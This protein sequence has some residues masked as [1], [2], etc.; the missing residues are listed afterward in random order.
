MGQ[1]KP[2]L[3][4]WFKHETHAFNTFIAELLKNKIELKKK[5]EDCTKGD[6]LNAFFE[7]FGEKNLIQTL[8]EEKNLTPESLSLILHPL[9]QDSECRHQYEM[10]IRQFAVSDAAVKLADFVV[11][12]SHLSHWEWGGFS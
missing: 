5:L 1:G 3:K 4:K 8:I 7:E 6:I 2:Q 12:D 11:G 9:I 10:G